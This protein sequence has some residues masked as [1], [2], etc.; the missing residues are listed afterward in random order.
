MTYLILWCDTPERER[1]YL[2]KG[3]DPKFEAC[4]GQMGQSVSNSME[5]DALINEL[6]TLLEKE[7]PIYDSDSSDKNDLPHIIDAQLLVTG[8]IL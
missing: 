6:S 1:F 5:L 7:P 8:F 2:I 3:L 4:H